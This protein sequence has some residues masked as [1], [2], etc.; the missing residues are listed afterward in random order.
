MKKSNLNKA[1]SKLKKKN[2]KD[3]IAGSNIATYFQPAEKNFVVEENNKHGVDP[4]N[5]YVE[6]LKKKLRGK[7]TI[8]TFCTFVLKQLCDT[9]KYLQDAAVQSQSGTSKAVHCESTAKE[10]SQSKQGPHSVD[11]ES[12]CVGVPE[13][14]LPGKQR[15]LPLLLIM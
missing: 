15:C 1:E 5:I 6:A 4:T 3:K 11:G 8:L 10:D 14:E 13:N 9:L 12:S 2:V 7:Y